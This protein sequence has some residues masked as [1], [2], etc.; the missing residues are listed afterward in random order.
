MSG[1]MR[2]RLVFSLMVALG[3]NA[4]A[5]PAMPPF[6]AIT[7]DDTVLVVAPHPDDESLCCGGLIH[8]ARSAGAHVAIVWITNGDGF[9][10]DAMV[11]ERKLRPRAGTYLELAR[12]RE[13][14]ARNAGGLLGVE[15]D[16]LMFLGYPDRG[17]LRLLLDYYHPDTPW[18]SK[19]TGANA[20]VYEDAVDPGAAYRGDN[21]VK[22]FNSVLDRVKP[23]LVLA[24]SP[25]DTHPD[26]RGTGLLVWRTMSARGEQDRVRYWIVHGGRGWPAPHG[27]HPGLDQTVAPRGLGMQWEAFS[28]DSDAIDAKLRA[29]SAHQSQ[30]K[31]MRRI[32]LSYVRSDEIYS[33]VPIPPRSSCAHPLVCEQDEESTLMEKSGL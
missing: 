2:M 4:L 22:D 16:S 30:M 24:P 17:V 28:L 19:F 3:G 8:A 25:Q 13:A 14:E 33:S 21:L 12:Q 32:M 6:R 20:V 1:M 18:R 23:T 29:V 11:V 31:V 27:Y 10:W 7:A 9:K 26:H 5:Q 15:S